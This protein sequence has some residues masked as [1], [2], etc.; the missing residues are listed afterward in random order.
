MKNFRR[1]HGLLRAVLASISLGC[2]P[3]AAASLLPRVRPGFEFRVLNRGAG[4]G[5]RERHRH[6]R[7]LG[8]G[9]AWTACPLAKLE[10]RL[11]AVRSAA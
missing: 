5:R 7:C 6:E 9:S 1:N 11:Q 3:A 10:L 2:A 8:S 4:D